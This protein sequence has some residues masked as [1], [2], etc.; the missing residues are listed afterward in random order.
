MVLGGGGYL[1]HE[2]KLEF[3][4]CSEVLVNRSCMY[5][6]AALIIL[7]GLVPALALLYAV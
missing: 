3:V 1:V 6:G 2:L 7:R 4:L 5:F